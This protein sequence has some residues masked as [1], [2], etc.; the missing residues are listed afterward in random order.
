M[1][2]VWDN[3]T[4]SVTCPV[5]KSVLAVS[6]GDINANEMGH[7]GDEFQCTCGSCSACI[8]IES[9]KIP[10]RWLSYFYGNDVY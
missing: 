2:V 5:C 4:V 3:D 9:S 10:R 6:K 8:N 1:R 7:Y